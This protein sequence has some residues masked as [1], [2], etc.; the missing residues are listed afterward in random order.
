MSEQRPTPCRDQTGQAHHTVGS[1]D[2]PAGKL[3][4]LDVGLARI[5]VSVCDPLQLRARPVTVVH[6]ASRRE[7]FDHIATLVSDENAEAVVCGLPLN[8]DGSEGYQARYVRKWALRLAHALRALLGKPVPILFWDERLT[9]VGAGELVEPSD[10]WTG[11]ASIGDSSIGEDAVAA[12][13][14]LQRY[15][16]R[17]ENREELDLGAIV[18]P[19][20]KAHSAPPAEYNRSNRLTSAAHE[21]STT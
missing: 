1:S 5:G 13:L 15:L 18:L 17:G 21:G 2:V 10:A 14:I 16:E 9:T 12:A 4:G 8:M 7:D 6:R 19:A 3:L 20:K 11:D